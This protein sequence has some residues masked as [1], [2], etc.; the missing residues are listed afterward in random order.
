MKSIIIN[1]SGDASELVLTTSQ[2][3]S[4]GDNE[5][6][7][8]ISVAGINFLDLGVRKGVLWTEMEYPKTLGVEGVGIVLSVGK[9]VRDFSPGER[10]A[11]VYAPGSYAEEI[12]IHAENLVHVPDSIDDEIVASLMMQGLTASHFA[13]EFYP[14]KTG[15]V[16]LVHAAAGGVGTLLTQ[17]IKLR[18]GLL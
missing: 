8:K 10:V 14:I 17:I 4:P 12:N 7:V 18:G 3:D 5:V 1:Q 11:W 6:Q 9:N 15:D 13:T 16:A 2:L